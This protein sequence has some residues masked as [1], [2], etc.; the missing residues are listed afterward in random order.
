MKPASGNQCPRALP[1]GPIAPISFG[2]STISETHQDRI[3]FDLKQ[4]SFEKSEGMRTLFA[5][6]S[7]TT[8]SQ[9]KL[10]TPQIIRS[11][12]QGPRTIYRA[13]TM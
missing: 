6:K 4:K 2:D 12:R 11:I 7:A 10:K 1:I 5:K 13:W 3:A 8:I 9:P